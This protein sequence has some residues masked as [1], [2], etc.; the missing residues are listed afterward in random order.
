MPAARGAF[1]LIG[2]TGAI[3]ASLLAAA[4]PARAN[5]MAVPVYSVDGG[6]APIATEAGAISQ[7]RSRLLPV[8]LPPADWL[9]LSGLVG[10][11]VLARRRR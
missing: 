9:L 8:P 11:G 10:F 5:E 6:P 3:V 1:R 7:S 2:V 4:A